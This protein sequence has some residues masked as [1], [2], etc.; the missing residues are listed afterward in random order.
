[1]DT[2]S[3]NDTGIVQIDYLLAGGSEEDSKR[4][5]LATPMAMF[6]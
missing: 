4:F 6:R 1:M 2:K 3:V 5:T